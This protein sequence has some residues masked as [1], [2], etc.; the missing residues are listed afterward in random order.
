[1]VGLGI[2][3]SKSVIRHLDI[4]GNFADM[5]QLL[6]AGTWFSCTSVEHCAVILEKELFPTVVRVDIPFSSDRREMFS[7][8]IPTAAET[9]LN[10]SLRSMGKGMS[11]ITTVGKSSF[12]NF[13][14][15]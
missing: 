5:S 7:E 4:V 6:L 13:T 9:V 2:A 1:M 14:A 12:F 3:C 11:T 15:E 10:N 8:Q